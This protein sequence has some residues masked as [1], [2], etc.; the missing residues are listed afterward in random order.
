MIIKFIDRSWLDPHR[1]ISSRRAIESPDPITMF[2][3]AA[4]CRTLRWAVRC[5]TDERDGT[6]HCQRCWQ[7]MIGALPASWS[8]EWRLPPPL[9]FSTMEGKD[10]DQLL[11]AA[12]NLAG[13][14]RPRARMTGVLLRTAGHAERRA[15]TLSATAT[16]LEPPAGLMRR[17]YTFYDSPSWTP[18]VL[19]LAE[20]WVG[21]ALPPECIRAGAMFS[22]LAVSLGRC[23]TDAERG[24]CWILDAAD[25]ARMLVDRE[26]CDRG[27]RSVTAWHVR[28]Y[29]ARN[30]APRT[31]PLYEVLLL[32]AP[33][34]STMASPAGRAHAYALILCPDR[35][36]G[37]VDSAA[38][39]NAAYGP[40]PARP[41]PPRTRWRRLLQKWARTQSPRAGAGI[42]WY[43]S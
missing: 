38:A 1:Q 23:P 25:G 2:R 30:G 19:A 16:K 37:A 27:R 3:V 36:A 20:C 32:H 8:R 14:P 22:E 6:A 15:G 31:T 13:S 9:A 29:A 21:A 5:V 10:A 17:L 11:A 28:L 18:A 43:P 35:C 26:F 41:S 42:Y 24:C 34:H 40:S 4:T 39:I 12:Q 33:P 7:A